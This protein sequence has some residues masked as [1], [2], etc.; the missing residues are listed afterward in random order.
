MSEVENI[1][2]EDEIAQQKHSQTA[3]NAAALTLEALVGRW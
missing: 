3:I 2:K 1:Y